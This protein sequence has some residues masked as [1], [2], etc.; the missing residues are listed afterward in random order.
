[1]N[2]Y[3]VVLLYSSFHHGISKCFISI[4]YSTLQG[5]KWPID[6]H[7]AGGSSR[8]QMGDNPSLTDP[9]FPP[10]RAK[11]CLGHWVPQPLS[12]VIA[13]CHHL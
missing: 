7:T 3:N 1:M 10:A 12:S 8:L 2:Y 9:S 13:P 4:N 11:L 6:T 5:G